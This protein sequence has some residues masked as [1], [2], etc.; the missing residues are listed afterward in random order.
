MN[1]ATSSLTRA[2]WQQLL[3]DAYPDSTT[4]TGVRKRSTGNDEAFA[5]PPG[6]DFEIVLRDMVGGPEGRTTILLRDPRGG[7]PD[8]VKACLDLSKP[9][10]IVDHLKILYS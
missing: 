2:D 3:I 4:E 5:R 8:R 6:K 7:A 10:I 9:G 1:E